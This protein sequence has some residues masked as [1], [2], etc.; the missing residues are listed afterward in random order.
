MAGVMVNVR[1]IE[2]RGIRVKTLHRPLRGTLIR[3]LVSAPVV[4]PEYAHPCLK[5]MKKEKY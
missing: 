5:S 3:F 2:G 4:I 1:H